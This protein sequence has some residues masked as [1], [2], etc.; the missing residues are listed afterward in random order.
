MTRAL[1]V[2]LATASAVSAQPTRFQFKAGDAFATSVEQSTTVTETRPAEG[3]KPAETLTS[4]A[5]LWLTRRWTVRAVDP[6]GVATLDLT[7]TA[8][9][10]E[11]APA[12]VAGQKAETITIDS[13]TPEGRAALKGALDQVVMTVKLDPGGKLLSAESPGGA[14]TGRVDA[15]LPLRVVWPDA[16]V[17]AGTPWTRTITLTLDPPQGAGEKVELAQTYTLKGTSQGVWVIGVT[18]APAS[19][20]KDPAIRLAVA[21]VLWA[22]DVY[23]DPA[24]GRYA[25]CRLEVKREV[26]DFAGPGTAFRYESK[27][28]EAA[29]K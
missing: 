3:T 12:P 1:L 21:P 26:A 15:E 9:K 25:G 22:G 13:A 4:T 2:L 14:P 6:A 18:T 28:V 10:Q 19:E 29:A 11:I 24:T 8:M 20:S 5:K 27:L 16:P 7:L 23:F 17:V